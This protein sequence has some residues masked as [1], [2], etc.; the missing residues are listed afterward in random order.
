MGMEAQG[1]T[2]QLCRSLSLS[3]G[4]GWT[5]RA[6]LPGPTIGSTEQS[7]CMKGVANHSQNKYPNMACYA[8]G[9]LLY[10]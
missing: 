6:P 7:F 1:L 4:Q 8:S 5:E 3:W 2:Q 9:H 10:I